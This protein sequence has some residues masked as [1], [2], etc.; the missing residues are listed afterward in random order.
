MP[1]ST[2]KA[3]TSQTRPMP[4]SPHLQVWRWHITMAASILHRASGIGA[5]GGLILL[6]AWLACLALGREAYTVFLSLAA[7]PLGLA[8]W[9]LASLAAFVH[10]FG[11]LRHL[12]WDLGL[13]LKPATA[14]SLAWTSLI[15][16]VVAT[17]GLWVG[18]AAT[19][20]VTL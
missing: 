6:V 15:L 14:S 18:L 8:V 17:I 5:A 7:S 16:A 9:V 11:G 12:I 19:G 2:P 10:L 20:R 4:L 1:G 13:G 3:Q